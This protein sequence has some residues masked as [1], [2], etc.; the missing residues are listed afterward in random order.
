MSNATPAAPTSTQAVLVTG[1]AGF[2][3]SEIVRRLV[4]EGRGVTVVDRLD[5]ERQRRVAAELVA[6]GARVV[7]ADLATADLRG[8]LA[9]AHGVVHLAGR[10]G[11]QQSWGDGFD[12]YLADNVSVTA[13]LL[14]AL[15]EHRGATLDSDVTPRIVLASSSSVYGTVPHGF[16]TERTAPA[17]VSPYGVS[18]A[19]VELLAGTYAARGVPVASLRYFTVYG[20]GQ[21]PDMAISRMID[22]TLTGSPFFVWGDGHQER[23]LTHVADVARATIAALDADLAAGAVLNVGSGRPVR[24]LEVIEGVGRLLGRPVPVAPAPDAAGD[25]ARTAADHSLAT[26]LL[27]WRPEVALDDGLADQVDAH[28]HRTGAARG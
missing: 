28:L 12:R 5:G 26:E 13:R 23:D 8:L 9:D 10:P 24:L 22:A 2:I 1:G 20:R 25:P 7:V 6:L 19:A 4:S 18:K 16:V 11:V 14:D 27:G 17:P 21:R 3:G 15:A